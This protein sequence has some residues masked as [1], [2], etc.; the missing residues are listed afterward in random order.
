MWIAVTK[1]NSPVKPGRLD[2][3]RPGLGLW[4]L[5]PLSTIFQLYCGSQFYWWRKLD[6]AS[7]LND[8]E[9]KFISMKDNIIKLCNK[10][11]AITRERHKGILSYQDGL[12]QLPK[13]LMFL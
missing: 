9:S 1:I 12:E 3:M 11:K 5:T 8:Y 4:C 10:S 13:K 2:L 7:V 6:V